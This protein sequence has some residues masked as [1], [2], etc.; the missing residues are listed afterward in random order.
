MSH[1]D[2]AAIGSLT[3]RSVKTVLGAGHQDVSTGNPRSLM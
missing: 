1:P 3:A 2:A